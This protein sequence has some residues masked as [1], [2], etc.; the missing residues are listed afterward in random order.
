MKIGARTLQILKNYSTIN[1]SLLFKPGSNLVTMSPSKTM[2]VKATV[3]EDFSQQFAIYDLSRLLGVLSLFDDP[4]LELNSKHLTVKGNGHSVNYTY[5]DISMIEVP[6]DKEI[7]LENPEIEF[8]LTGENLTAIQ[9][10]LGVLGQPEIAVIGDRDKIYIA[11]MDAKN[12]FSDQ[13]KIEVGS[14][15]HEFQIV[16]KAE[17]IKLLNATYQVRIQS[18]GVGHFKTDD[19]EYWIVAEASSSFSE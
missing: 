12:P 8:V 17:N 1:P 10:A 19:I 11:T 4:D 6:P 18:K 5:A 2:M 13:Y 15:S 3:V 16:F 14:T 7:P 9:R